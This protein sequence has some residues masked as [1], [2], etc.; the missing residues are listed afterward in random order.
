MRKNGLFI[1]LS[2]VLLAGAAAAVLTV[3]PAVVG[4]TG[5]TTL[6]PRPSIPVLTL[7]ERTQPALTPTVYEH[8]SVGTASGHTVLVSVRRQPLIFWS[9]NL[10]GKRLVEELVAIHGDRALRPK[11]PPGPE[12]PGRTDRP[13]L[14]ATG[15]PP[16]LSRHRAI[17]ETESLLRAV[18][19]TWRCDYLWGDP[20]E[21]V[22]SGVPDTYVWRRSGRTGHGRVW[23]IPGLLLT[24]AEWAQALA[25]RTGRR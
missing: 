25:G 11:V 1:G 18:H 9:P 14:I 6:P 20:F 22:V 15:F 7:K 5:A 2:A 19:L 8:L 16:G 12:R 24:P 4:P 3:S 17:R 13:L 23:H 21:R 10:G